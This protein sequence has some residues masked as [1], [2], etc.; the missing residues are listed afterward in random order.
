MPEVIVIG[1]GLAGM[2]A[3]AALGSAGYRVTLFESRS[4]L[5]GR[6]TSFPLP[7][8]ESQSQSTTHKLA[9]PLIDNCQHI[10][11]RCC[12]NLLDFY[13][14]F[15]ALDKIHF[16]RELYFIEPGGRVSILQGRLLPAPLHFGVSFLRLKFLSPSDKLSVARA[17]S[18][19]RRERIPRQDLDRITMLDWLKE[20]RQSPRAIERFWRQILVS[21]VN[22]ELDSMAARHGFQVFW[23]GFLARS[24]SYEMGI[25]AVP[26]GELYASDSWKKLRNVTVRLR[27][28]VQQVRLEG[29]A[30]DSVQVNGEWQK[31]DYYICALPFERLPS[32]SLTWPVSAT[33]RSPESTS[34]LIGRLRSCHMPFYLIGRS[35]GCLTRRKGGTSN[36]W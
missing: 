20:K 28:P 15:D 30:V 8:S 16:H 33:P 1:G 10:L 21:A 35:S 27:S 6:A 5:G 34:G 29:K 11:L 2:A 13:E 36:S 18:S 9:G 26:L 25:P 32:C 7:L 17:L 3:A 12:V 23:L 14:R 19:L 4:F 31:A 24:N 22:E